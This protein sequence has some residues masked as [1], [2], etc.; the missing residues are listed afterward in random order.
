M[1]EL[2]P[3][4]VPKDPP[5]D[6]PYWMPHIHIDINTSLSADEIVG[7]IKQVVGDSRT[8][9]RYTDPERGTH[10]VR[11]WL[12]TVSGVNINLDLS[13]KVRNLEWVRNNMLREIVG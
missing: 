7:V 13:T 6:I 12:G 10:C 2:L 11:L 3:V 5:K 9:I 1:I 4:V 8:P